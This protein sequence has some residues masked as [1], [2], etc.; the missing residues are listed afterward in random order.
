MTPADIV[1]ASEF[2]A[3]LAAR[4]VEVGLMPP[5]PAPLRLAAPAAARPAARAD[6][7]PKAA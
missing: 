3:G 2:R 6:R 5:E 4:L 1:A 7:E